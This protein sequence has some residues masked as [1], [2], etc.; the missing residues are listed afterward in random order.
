MSVEAKVKML[1]HLLEKGQMGAEAKFTPGQLYTCLT[2]DDDSLPTPP[3]CATSGCTFYVIGDSVL[4]RYKDNGKHKDD[5]GKIWQ[6]STK[7][8]TKCI[9]LASCGLT[10]ITNALIGIIEE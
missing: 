9:P 6:E 10:E 1:Y 7:R 5:L 2:S 4:R 8:N 3:P